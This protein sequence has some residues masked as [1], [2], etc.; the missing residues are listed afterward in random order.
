LL[1]V[2][3]LIPAALQRWPEL[4]LDVRF[5]DRF[6]DVVEEGADLVIRISSELPDAA[7][8]LVR[9]LARSRR[10]LCASPAYLRAHGEP[11][12]LD[13]L[14]RHECLVYSGDRVPGQWTFRGADGPAHVR[15]RGRLVVD[16]SIVIRE[17][18]LAGVGIALLP[19]FYIGDELA[20]GT[21]RSILTRFEP[22]PVIVHAITN[23]SRHP[24]P[25]A[26]AFVDL[27]R[28][29]LAETKWAIR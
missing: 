27:L 9:R 25:R 7:S 29:H 14:S 13:D 15:V 24:P 11:R 21:L 23:R 16:S 22:K 10:V 5:T 1:H 8:I 3:P 2:A 18:L 4:A 6:I 28:D 17:A 20:S 12:S 19:A 26:R